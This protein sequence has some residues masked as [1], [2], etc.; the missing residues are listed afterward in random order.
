MVDI[1]KLTL[2]SLFYNS[3]E[4]YAD[5]TSI[6]FVGEQDYTYKEMGED[7]GLLAEFLIELGISKGDKVAILSTNMP[8]WGKAFFSI[9]L[10]GA[11]AVPI[12]PDFHKNEV[13]TI[14]EHSESKMLFVSEG[15]YGNVSDE[16]EALLGHM[17]MVENFA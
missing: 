13:K 7:V 16:T 12:L 5:K 3:V 17:I 1:S 8:N 14:I 4:K 2:P 15:L 11:V 10:I 9:S 6:V